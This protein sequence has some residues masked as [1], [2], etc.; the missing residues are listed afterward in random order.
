MKREAKNKKDPPA[1]RSINIRALARECGYSVGTV[2][3]ALNGNPMVKKAT[4]EKILGKAKELGYVPNII[5]QLISSRNSGAI[6][7]IVPNSLPPLFPSIIYGILRELEALDQPSFIVY[8]LDSPESE[9]Y[10]LKVF[11]QLRIQGLVAAL[12]PGSEAKPY[13]EQLRE[14]GTRIVL[15]DRKL[16]GFPSDYVGFE[17]DRPAEAAT[18]ALIAAGHRRIGIAGARVSYSVLD[19]RRK[20][21][22]AALKKHGLPL[23][24]NLELDLDYDHFPVREEEHIRNTAKLREFLDTE[25]PTAMVLALDSLERSLHEAAESLHLSIPGD[26]AVISFDDL[27]VES[28]VSGP[29]PIFS[30]GVE[31][32]QKA[33]HHLL[34]KIQKG[35]PAKQYRTSLIQTPLLSEVPP[36]NA[37]AS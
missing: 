10:Y 5:A 16:R 29:S 2:S 36:Q 33:A 12:C 28:T 13:L 37:T 4:A 25:R 15:I 14:N 1:H 26:L 7:V 34:E 8:S 17:N 19:E 20:G 21:Y 31:L 3:M 11:S 35:V 30:P 27:M 32:G 24:K 9:V 18:E 23:D 22:Q 6:G